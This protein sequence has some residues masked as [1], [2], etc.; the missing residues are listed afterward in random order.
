MSIR[1]ILVN[2]RGGSGKSACSRHLFDT[3]DS[4]ALIDFDSLTTVHPFNVG[5]ELFALGLGNAAGLIANFMSANYGA[6]IMSAGTGCQRHV[7]YLLDRIPSPDRLYWIW[8]A[9]N[10]EVRDKR[11][12]IRARDGADKIEELDYVDEV[13]ESYFGP[14]EIAAGVCQEIDTDDVTTDEVVEKILTMVDES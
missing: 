6:I 3:M 4:A 14:V 13:M 1:L 7:D 5:E 8:L 11:R 2:G 10:K 9:A 12:L